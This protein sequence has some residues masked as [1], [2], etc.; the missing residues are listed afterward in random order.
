M[1]GIW[2]NKF[3]FKTILKFLCCLLL[4]VIQK[5]PNNFFRSLLC[6]LSVQKDINIFGMIF[7]WQVNRGCIYTTWFSS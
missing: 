6:W 2:T 4:W 3:N 5:P 1:E 7:Y